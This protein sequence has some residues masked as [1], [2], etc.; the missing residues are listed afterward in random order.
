MSVSSVRVLLGGKS[1]ELEAKDGETLLSAL[2]RNGFTLPAACGG[3]GKCGKCRVKINGVS[4][5]ACRA[6][7]SDGDEVALPE[8]SGGRILTETPEILHAKGGLSGCAA[9]VDLGTTTV[10]VRLYDLE[11]GR[12]AATASAWNAQAAYGGD[13]ISRIRHT[14]DAPAGLSELSRIIRLQV[15]DMI[16]SALARC[17]RDKSE[18]RHSVLVGNT[19]MQHIFANFPVQS[20]AVAPFEPHTLFGVEL[21]DT[22]LGAPLYYAP[23]VAGYVGGDIT[24]GLL[25]S[26]LSNKDGRY[27]FLDIGTNGE[28][29]LGGK[30]GFRCCAVA[31]GPAFEGAGISCGMPA[32]DGAVSH[33]RFSGGFLYDTVGNTPPRGLCGSG[34]IDLIA[35]LLELGCIDDGG[36]LLPPDD[37]PEK[38]RRYLTCDADGNGVFHL[39]HEVYLTAQDVRNLQLAKAAVAAGISVLLAAESITVEKL[40]GV[41]LAGGFGSYLD[42]K[43]AVKIGMLPYLPPDKLH[44]T[45]NTALAGASI[46]ALDTEKIGCVRKIAQGCDYIELSGRADFA[47]AFAENIAF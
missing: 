6:A 43:S 15:K 26:G 19:V 33:V 16:G 42:P 28:M 18:L 47:A 10:A 38:M 29:A 44:N 1:F 39:T 17:G 7:I 41:Y 13:V 4:R 32:I 20:I 45:G 5:L 37:A 11:T 22:L 24:A 35:A 30:G 9:A 34:L 27:L 40:D 21:D 23:C 25:A 31:S 3:R 8:S 2:R 46:M 14:M 12:E 36:R